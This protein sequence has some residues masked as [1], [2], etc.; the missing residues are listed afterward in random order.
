MKIILSCGFGKLHFHETALAAARAG[1]N[2]EFIVGW[3]PSASSQR[4]VDALG[5]CIGE[6]SLFNRLRAR[7]VDHPRVTVRSNA[8]ADFSVQAITRAL[9][10][11][12]TSGEL[13]GIWLQLA[14]MASR[15]WLH[16]ADIFH[17]RSGVGQGGAIHT[18][19]RNGLR[20]LTD[21]SIAHPV[22]MDK[23]LREEHDRLGLPFEEI[24]ANGLWTRVLRDCEQ[25]DRL[26]VNS[27]FV[28]RTFVEQG[29]APEKI[30]V[31]YLGVREQ[32]FSLKQD[33]ALAGPVRLL[34]TGNFSVR[35]GASTLLE[36]IRILRHDGLD[37]FLRVIGRL[38]DGAVCLRD[39]DAEF[40]THMPFV[41]PDEL[42]P[43]FA[44]ADLFVF[45]TLIEGSSRS[46]MEAAAAGLPIVT[47]E[48]C[49]LPLENE[50]EVLYVP[51]SD[52][53]TLAAAIAR[54]A[55]DERLRS[56]LGRNAAACIQ[57]KYTW[58]TYGRELYRIYS[59]LRR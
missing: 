58:H 12:L 22:Y 48:S 1:V 28:K 36:A 47:T 40:F 27:G 16:E 2:V 37:V 13:G 9:R 24:A 38:A 46:A 7:T 8:L 29:F 20:V 6:T 45:P 51:S 10:P 19:R 23:V 21:H 14:G 56:S 33:Y 52:A 30:D 39:S 35:K 4:L 17:V 11:V 32:F 53:Q 41:P 43:A 31:A 50:K 34:F 5:S 42:L 57:E 54:L 15:K 3:V 55:T 26:L 25:A 49:G 59:E 44:K 18:A